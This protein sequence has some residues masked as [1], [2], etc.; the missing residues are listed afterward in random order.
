VL[1]DLCT[2]FWQNTYLG[3][4]LLTWVQNGPVGFG[5]TWHMKRTIYL[6]NND[7]LVSVGLQRTNRKTVKI[8]TLN[9]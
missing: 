1:D 6:P 9:Q 8:V 2:K 5:K 7:Y 3:L 4:F